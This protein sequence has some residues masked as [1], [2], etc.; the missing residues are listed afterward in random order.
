ML[1][2]TMSEDASIGFSFLLKSILFFKGISCVLY[3]RTSAC[4]WCTVLLLHPA[5]MGSDVPSRAYDPCGMASV[6]DSCPGTVV[7]HTLCTGQSVRE[8]AQGWILCGNTE[9]LEIYP[10]PLACPAFTASREH[11]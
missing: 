3:K 11:C 7:V 2:G 9:C 1:A 10:S 4:I 8:K 6:L 5:D